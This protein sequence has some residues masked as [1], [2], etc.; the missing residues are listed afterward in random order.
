MRAA[1]R[2]RVTGS[3]KAL[4]NHRQYSRAAGLPLVP[5]ECKRNLRAD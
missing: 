1:Q 2:K 4:D 5:L 3:L